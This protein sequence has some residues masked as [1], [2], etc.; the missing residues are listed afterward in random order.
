LEDA[1]HV[2]LDLLEAVGIVDLEFL[3]ILDNLL[4]DDISLL[5]EVG[6][7]LI[8]CRNPSGET[9]DPG[10]PKFLSGGDLLS[11]DGELFLIFG[12]FVL[13]F[14][15]GDVKIFLSDLG[16]SDVGSESGEFLF[17]LGDLS[18]LSSQL[19]DV[20]LEDIG[21]LTSE[22][23][24]GLSMILELGELGVADSV[25]K[26]SFATTE[27]ILDREQLE[28]ILFLDV[29]TELPVDDVIELGIN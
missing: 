26:A 19:L 22:S 2:R 6:D 16:L 24:H 9:F 4:E 7:F 13:S 12:K 28:S 15:L 23:G 3:G 25:S 20:V 27:V 8:S 1:H 5:L 29:V 14:S 21:V 11:H 10:L 18:E 17:N